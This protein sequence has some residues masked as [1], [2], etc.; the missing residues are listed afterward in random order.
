[1]ACCGSACKVSKLELM[2]CLTAIHRDQAHHRREAAAHQ[3]REDGLLVRRCRPPTQGADR[4]GREASHRAVVC[5]CDPHSVYSRQVGHASI[6]LA[7]WVQCLSRD[8]PVSYMQLGAADPFRVFE[9]G[10]S[11]GPFD[12]GH[13]GRLQLFDFNHTAWSC[14]KDRKR[15]LRGHR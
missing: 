4:D 2:A 7:W 12:D 3:R 1:M 5:S 6:Y 11:C 9:D 13:S 8:T 10:R 15:Q 14:L